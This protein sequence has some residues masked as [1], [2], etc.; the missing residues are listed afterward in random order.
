MSDTYEIDG[1]TITPKGGGVYELSHPSL[2]EPAMERGKEKA[3]ARARA[4]GAALKIDDDG[5]SMSQQGE[6]NA[7]QLQQ[8]AAAL[9][10]KPS[11]EKQDA[12]PDANEL[13]RLRDELA[14]ANAKAEAATERAEKLEIEV[15]TVRTTE[16]AT[17][18][19]QPAVGVVPAGVPRK[20]AGELNEDVKETLGKLGIETT[21]IILE[22]STDIPPTGL[23]LGHN[24]RGYVIVPGEKVT[25]PNFLLGVL[26]DA[27]M[28]SPVVDSKTQKVLGYRDRMKYPYR[29]V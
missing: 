11:P 21:D 9:T 5:A 24:G 15:K 6:I 12:N 14:A 20:F 25:V 17:P 8:A 29:R 2:P 13:A 1:V 7:E 3:D 26:N 28:S 16:G 19:A 18:S 4:I 23:F 27:V 10:E 22:E